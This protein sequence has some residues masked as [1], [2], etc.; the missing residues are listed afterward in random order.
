VAVEVFKEGARINTT[1]NPAVPSSLNSGIDPS[2][3]FHPRLHPNFPDQGPLTLWTVNGTLPPKLLQVRYGEPVLFRDHN[4]LPPDRTQNGGFGRNETTTHEHNGHHGAENDGFTGAY[5]FPGEFYD[6]HW[7]IVLAGLDTINTDASDPRAGSPDGSG[8]IMKVPG[9]WHETMSSHWF[10][11]HRFGFT[12]Q[13]VY[14]GMIAMFNIYSAL[15][16]GNEEIND[17]V[18]LRLP[19]GTANDFGN[20][21]YDINL[22]VEDKALSPEG[23]LFFDIFDFDGFLGDLMTANFVYKPFFEVE[24]RKYRF[25]ILNG[26]P[27][28]FVQ[29]QLSDNSPMIQ[30]GNDGNLMPAP[31]PLNRLDFQGTA[32]RY[33]V[34]IDFSRYRVGD[35]VWLV[36]VS[37]HEDGK[38]PKRTVPLD[39]ALAGKSEDPCVGK[40]LE[41]RIVRDPAKPDISQVPEVMIPNPDLSNIPV[42]R[43]RTFEFGDGADQDTDDP[44]TSAL[45]GRPWGIKTDNQGPMLEA[46]FGRISAAPKFGT[47]EIWTIR[48]GGGGW[49]HPIHIH[50]EEGIILA[51]DGSASNVPPWERG[52]KDIYRLHPSGS[53]TVSIQFRDWGG[54]FMEHCHNTV[55]EDN[56]M[57]LRWEIDDG[58]TPFLRPLPT[59]IPTPQGVTFRSPDDIFPTAFEAGAKQSSD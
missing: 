7:P 6:Y 51:R 40:F 20:L 8:G 58:G 15:D 16:R 47:R 23:Q 57:L 55:H 29:L 26:S 9:D 43:E 27:S 32:E 37:E 34:V 35:K 45:R 39:E 41:F 24:R 46:D 36:N 38:R 56:A 10:H 2:Q 49:D 17:G 25:R 30:I 52:R 4:R 14:K 50:F 22:L 5:F 3:P 28:R 53:V 11:D 59:P 44:V 54:M 42:S 1:Y 13:N 48:N 33:D 31:V 21:D 12:S 18:N 19:S